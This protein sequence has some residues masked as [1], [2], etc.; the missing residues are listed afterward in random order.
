VAVT[1]RGG[2]P[3]VV[4]RDRFAG[5]HTVDTATGK[6]WTAVSFR[7]DTLAL[8]RETQAGQPS[9]GIRHL[10]HVVAVGGGRMIEAG[11]SLVA[12]IGVSGAPG[13]DADDACARAGIQAVSADLEF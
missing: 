7:M 8:A 6:A 13:G 11:G 2:V 5:P 9:S 3:I 12:G 4:L 10:P 1:D